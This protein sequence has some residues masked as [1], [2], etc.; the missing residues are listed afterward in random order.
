MT[1]MA[2]DRLATLGSSRAGV[3]GDIA[4]RRG[5]WADVHFGAAA[6]HDLRSEWDCLVP[7]QRSPILFQMPEMLSAWAEHFAADTGSVLATVVVRREDG[8]AVLIWP[9]LVERKGLVRIARG[10]SNPVGQ[11]DEFLLDPECD[12][13]TAFTAAIA[14]L[15]RSARPDLFFLERVRADSA[16][17]TAI[18][19]FAVPSKS[20]GAP[21]SDTSRGAEALFATL[22]S[23]V[24]QQHRKRER[25]LD[26]EG[27]VRFE[28]A[29]NA[30]DAER[31]LVEAMAIKREWLRS[32]GRFSRAFARSELADLLIQ[33]A[34]TLTGPGASPRMV[35][36][37][38]SVNGRTAAIEIGFVH[39]AT[40][41]SYM[42]AFSPEF[43]KFGAG[44]IL[45]AKLL[46]WCGQNGIE[47]FDMQS[48]RARSKTD[49]QTSEV[50]VFDF[51]LPTTWRG[52]LYLE[53]FV[54]RIIPAAR[55]AFY[56]MPP[57]VRSTLAGLVLRRLGRELGRL[58]HASSDD[59]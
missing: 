37:R 16:L 30:A 21:Y 38:L 34:R 39:R 50:E 47:K 12:E 46:E 59:A 56:R 5:L 7:L 54:K 26:Q 42:G 31:W 57:G 20:E 32:T 28:V 48:P 51:A 27:A 3:A 18:G 33:Y 22:K 4:V 1:D 2:L 25:R 43:A 13:A 24:V 41:H 9:I 58:N 36:S 53:G 44:N 40:C 17:R 52:R 6:Y 11:Y 15:K 23:R 49:W 45:S 29:D 8:R 35:V 19:P 10:A 55:N 14:A